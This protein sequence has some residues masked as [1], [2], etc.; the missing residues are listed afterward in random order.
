MTTTEHTRRG[1]APLRAEVSLHLGEVRWLVLPERPAGTE[2]M[3]ED[4]LVSLI[5]RDAMVAVAKVKAP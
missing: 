3:S 4:E 5:T 1:P 2:G